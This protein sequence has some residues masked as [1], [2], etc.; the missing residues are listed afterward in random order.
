MLH[1]LKILFYDPIYNL[2]VFFIDFVPRHDVGISIILVILLVRFLIAPISKKAYLTQLK[3]KAIQPKVEEIKKR[4]GANREEQAKKLVALYQEAEISFS[5]ILLLPFVQLPILISLY[6]IFAQSGLPLIKEESLYFFVS[7]PE[8][9][10][11]LFLGLQNLSEKSIPFAL[12]AGV[13]AYFQGTLLRGS[14]TPPS[15]GKPSFQHDLARSMEINMR[16]VFP[17]MIAVFSYTS[18]AIALYFMVSGVFSYIQESLLR[19]KFSSPTLK[20]TL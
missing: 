2:F 1:F 8:K 9:V 17:V 7:A 14:M 16:Y 15:S 4:F 13:V 5:S 19:K 18:S 6:Y 3:T 10:N 20:T 11:M 12:I